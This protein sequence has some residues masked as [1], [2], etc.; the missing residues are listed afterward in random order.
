VI[1]KWFAK[2]YINIMRTTLMLDDD[3]LF[4]AREIASTQELSLGEIVSQL[5]RRG[6]EGTPTVGSK[7][8]LPVFRRGKPHGKVL[9]ETVLRA[10]DDE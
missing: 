5:A 3:L 4:E 2:P 1:E 10:Q 6:L 9:L 8:N 7:D